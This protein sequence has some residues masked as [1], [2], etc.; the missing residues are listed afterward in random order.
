MTMPYMEVS[1]SIYGMAMPYMEVPYME[2]STS[3]YGMACM[4]DGNFGNVSAG[5]L[6]SEVACQQRKTVVKFSKKLKKNVFSV[7]VFQSTTTKCNKI[8]TC[9][10]C[11]SFFAN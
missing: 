3:I 10:A 1:T 4:I 11:A 2:V 6:F 7:S 8:R 9:G 5:V